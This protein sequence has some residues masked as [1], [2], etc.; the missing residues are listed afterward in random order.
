[1]TGR[2]SAVMRLETATRYYLVMVQQ[3]LFG[4]WELWRAWGCRGAALGN[5]M[6]TPARDEAH[7]EQLLTDV[8]ERRRARGYQLVPAR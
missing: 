6:R 1:M 8:L 4:C 7:A 3:D 5:D 2:V